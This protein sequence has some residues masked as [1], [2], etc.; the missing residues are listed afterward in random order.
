MQYDF[1]HNIFKNV[2]YDKMS[3]TTFIYVTN[4]KIDFFSYAI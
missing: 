1:L 2:K 3:T 4:K